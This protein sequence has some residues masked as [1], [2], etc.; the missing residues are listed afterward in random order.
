MYQYSDEELAGLRAIAEAKGVELIPPIIFEPTDGEDGD[1][2]A[3]VTRGA[4][5]QET[6][7]WY[8]SFE[9]VGELAEKNL[10][11]VI[12]LA[13]DGKTGGS[14]IQALN[15]LADMSSGFMSTIVMKAIRPLGLR[16]E[17][18]AQWL[19]LNRR[20]TPDDI[21]RAGLLASAADDVLS[22]LQ[23]HTQPGALRMLRI[24]GLCSLVVRRPTDAEEQDHIDA[25]KTRRSR[26]FGEKV[27]YAF[28]HVVYPAGEAER[29]EIFAKW[30][31]LCIRVCSLLGQMR[32]GGTSEGKAGRSR[33]SG[34]K[35]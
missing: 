4:T 15:D 12:V 16:H 24:D 35:N 11:K 34:R 17:D 33:S 23:K 21:V 31:A 26:I 7:E 5:R 13:V 8:A 14:V 22:L 1:E 27:D 10:A 18:E 32:S 28:S 30:P 3:V 29:R 25:I 20:T 19:P 2:I 6:A 9:D